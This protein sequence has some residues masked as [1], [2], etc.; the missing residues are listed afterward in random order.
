MKPKR[1]VTIGGGTGSFT[2]LSGLKKYPI[3]ISAIVSMADDGGSTGILRD[4]LGVLPPGDVRQCLV[5]LSESSEI[6]RKLL[7]YRFESGGL[8]GH[9]FGNLFLSALEKINGSFSGGVKEAAK[10]LNIKGEVIPVTDESMRLFVRLKNGKLIKGE[11]ELDKNE[12]ISKIGV[13][14]VFLKPKIKANQEA[15]ERIKK[16]DCIIIGPG[17]FYGSIIP[18]LLVSGIAQAIKKSKAEVVFNCNLTNKK[19]Q[20][21]NFDLD[22][23]IDETNKYLGKNRINYAIFNTQIPKAELI[24]KY[25]HREG[26]GMMVKFDK[27][28][29]LKRNF[30]VIRAKVLNEKEA[31]KDKKDSIA[32]TRSFIRHDSEKLAKI[33]MIL[34]EIKDY[35][36][37]IKEIA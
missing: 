9:N 28:K 6:L 12:E 13:K 21:E 29:N 23:Y 1:I 7:N 22:R 35:E 16:A 26:R 8:R 19:G 25:E 10:I 5:A 30:R 33:L 27:N 2:L 37:I 32:H 11:N 4:E 24:K 31:G 20:T 17:D 36:N 15:V 14:K 3:D 34:L 18:N